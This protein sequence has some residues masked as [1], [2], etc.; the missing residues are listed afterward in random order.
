ML[1]PNLS[2]TNSAK[3]D[4]QND[5]NNNESIVIDS[6]TTKSSQ[7][8]TISIEDRMEKLEKLIEKR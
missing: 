1:T 8:K 4:S 7:P 6:Q 2:D 3:N 5:E